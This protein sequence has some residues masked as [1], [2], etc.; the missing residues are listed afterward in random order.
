MTKTRLP[1]LPLSL[2][3][4]ILFAA[5]LATACSTTVDGPVATDQLV[6]QVCLRGKSMADAK[7]LDFTIVRADKRDIEPAM[8]VG[9]SV[10]QQPVFEA[11]ADHLAT[12]KTTVLSI[13]R[14]NWYGFTPPAN[15]SLATWSD[16]Q[17]AA[18]VSH[19]EDV[20]YKLQ[21]DLDFEKETDSKAAGAVQVR[22][23]MMHYKD[24][25][26]TRASRRLELPHTDFLPC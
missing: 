10:K 2:H 17:A 4:A 18:Y 5:F 21:H 15:A 24:V 14:T 8:A 3:L 22:Y 20:A 19:A 9:T 11:V 12:V 26:A 13:D 25:L 6:F 23:R 1:S 7:Q 16:W